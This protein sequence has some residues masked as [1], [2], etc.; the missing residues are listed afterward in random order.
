MGTVS[1]ALSEEALAQCVTRSLYEPAS[2]IAGIEND[3]TKCSICQVMLY[4]FPLS[5]TLIGAIYIF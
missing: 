4:S 2:L 5:G 1:T 3:D